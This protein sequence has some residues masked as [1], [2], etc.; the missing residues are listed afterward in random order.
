MLNQ[1]IYVYFIN[2][3]LF[4]G[5]DFKK[6]K[7]VKFDELNRFMLMSSYKFRISNIRFLHFKK[8]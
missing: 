6:S 1:K 7:N 4:K 5:N 8:R 2:K 3:L